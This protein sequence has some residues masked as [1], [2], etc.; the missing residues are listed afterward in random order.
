MAPAA[1]VDGEQGAGAA[2]TEV[3]CDTWLPP[4]SR[5]RR[6]RSEPCPRDRESAGDCIAAVAGLH[7]GPE[8]RRAAL[9]VI[10]GWVVAVAPTVRGGGAD[11]ASGLERR[12]RAL[13]AAY[14]VDPS[15]VGVAVLDESGQPRALLEA[16][17][18]LKPASNL[19]VL[20]TAAGWALLG[21]GRR[22]SRRVFAPAPVPVPAPVPEHEYL[23]R[24]VASAPLGAGV[25]AGDLIVEGRGDPNISGRFHEDDPLAVFRT[26]ARQLRRAGLRKIAGDFIA[27][28]SYFDAERFLPGWN[29]RNEGRWFSAEISP[30]S[31]EDNCVTVR[32]HPT[33]PG[34][35][36]RVE[37]T[38][39]SPFVTV[40]G[41]PRTVAGRSA[42]VRVHRAEGENRV[43]VSG[44]IGDR[45]SNW[46]DHVAVVDP[47][48]FFVHTLAAELA[49]EGIVIGGRVRRIAPS[50][51]R[52][53]ALVAGGRGE[54]L[55]E[56]RSRLGLDLPVI[57]KRSQNLH[58]EILLKTIGREV[59]GE[60][61]VAGGAQA[62][63][64]FVASL[65][66]DTTGLV[67]ADG[68]GLSADNR[69]SARQLAMTLWAVSS[70]PGFAAFLESLPVAG[71]D[72]TLEDR[73]SQYPELVGA[74][75]AKTGFIDSVSALSGFVERDGRRWSFAILVNRFTGDGLSAAKRLQESIVAR[76]HDVMGEAGATAGSTPAQCP[77]AG[78]R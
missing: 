20:T 41:A 50:D 54:V 17:T 28:D 16:D 57:N 29:R 23:T 70:R 10:S 38:P 71:V 34:Q 45:V 39:A 63:R 14:G 61:S 6:G 30:L 46:Y 51:A 12:I 33:A 49:R 11:A 2:V 68:S 3:Y 18:P 78:G 72:G 69:V 26:W 19:K 42:S 5:R 53:E 8:M 36:A 73:F 66:V 52:T 21:P 31:F 65:G 77:E 67:I 62:I 55:L 75:R 59:S 74:V 24:L 27:D 64:R 1:R 48:L 32:V 44:N 4:T 56:H 47:S 25:V 40:V 15:L 35:P 60:G 7:S 43:T 9:V 37:V 13:V 58:A 76:I 22:A